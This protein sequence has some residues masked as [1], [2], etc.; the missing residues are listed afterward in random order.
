MTPVDL[1]DVV[2][3]EQQAYAWPWSQGNFADSLRSGYH[4]IVLRGGARL[5]GYL[6]AM[7]GVEEAHL[8]NITVAPEFQR[9]G[10]ASL[11]LQALNLWA[12]GI[13][14]RC[15]WLEVRASNR[16]ALAVYEHQGFR[17]V[18]LRRGYYPHGG[19]P[20]G[21]QREDAVVMSHAL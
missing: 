8:L 16:Q 13:G 9:Q 7:P 6:V 19:G 18:G 1:A 20:D 3:V 2:A 11:L 14:A 17:R 12:R 15:L 10:H 21:R 5:V 4:A